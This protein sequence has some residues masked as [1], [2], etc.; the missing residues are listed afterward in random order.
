M[1]KEQIIKI[2]EKKNW[3][4][5]FIS[6]EISKNMIFDISVIVCSYN[7]TKEALFFTLR[8]IISQKDIEVEI[9]I[10]D[11]GSK[12]F[13]KDDIIAFFEKNKFVNWKIVCNE[14]NHGTV[15]NLYSALKVCNSR[16]VKFIS[17]GDALYGETILKRWK[18]FQYNAKS[19]WSF[20]DAIYYKNQSNE[21]ID[22]ECQAHPNNVKP[23]L[24]ND[25]DICR[26]NYIALDDIA[27][28]ACVFCETELAES[29]ISKIV[30]QVI[31]AEDNI[32]R[33]MMFDGI[34]GEY[35]PC[36]A[37]LYEYGTGISTS[38]S[39]IWFM[40]I[41][42]DWDKANEL[43]IQNKKLDNFQRKVVNTWKINEENNKIK[44]IFIRG[45]LKQYIVS[46]LHMRKTV[47]RD[48]M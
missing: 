10:A 2:D 40:R 23:Y 35:F 48:N 13:Y 29:Y 20:A 36:N 38:R 14:V 6:D 17:P 3:V 39:D 12:V 47:K 16:Y 37:V 7:P 24:K 5:E 21:Q 15:F 43:M 18:D 44:K 31:Y 8:S 19:K 46:K 32:W 33:M 27:L 22:L 25:R 9:I 30:N 42:K 34:V 45:K 41:K 26:W 11:D 28:G 4:H 1:V